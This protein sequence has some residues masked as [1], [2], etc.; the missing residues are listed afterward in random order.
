MVGILTLLMLALSPVSLGAIDFYRESDAGQPSIRLVAVA[1]L[2]PAVLASL[3]SLRYWWN[4]RSRFA[5][6]WNPASTYLN[7]GVWMACL[8][9]GLSLLLA[10][11]LVVTSG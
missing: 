6:Q 9:L 3:A 1:C 5:G 4:I 10:G 11:V 2:A 7:S 8:G